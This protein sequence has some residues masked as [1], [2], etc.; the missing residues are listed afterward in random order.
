MGASV[1]FSEQPLVFSCQGDLLVGV[2]CRPEKP[3]SVAVLIVVGGPQ[4]RAGSHRQFVLL[5]RALA[6]QGIASFRFD[7]RGMGD[8]SG[9][10]LGF[11]ATAEDISAALAVF[12][13]VEPSVSRFVLWGLCDGATAAAIYAPNDPRV[14][15]L[16]LL[17]PWVRT[18]SSQ[19]RTYLKHYYPK[20][21]LDADFWRKLLRGQIRLSDAIRRF[22]GTI[23]DLIGP[24]ETRESNAPELAGKIVDALHQAH[25]RSLIVLSGRDYVAREFEEAVAEVPL[26]S[27]LVAGDRIDL[28]HLKAADH[29][30]SSASH[31]NA[32]ADATA[33]WVKIAGRCDATL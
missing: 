5:A 6:E 23:P 4:Y 8:A 10:P 33:K 19:A 24:R 14:C 26:F 30:F 13:Q 7:V 15:G 17:N 29:T 20:R 2:V 28:L 16:V 3:A 18:A 12:S 32:V 27:E 11:A 9:E 21:L 1:S 22:I 25:G 31:R